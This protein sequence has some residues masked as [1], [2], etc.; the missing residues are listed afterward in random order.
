MN[1]EQLRNK[2]GAQMQ[3]N[4]STHLAK[5]KLQGHGIGRI[6]L[7]PKGLSIT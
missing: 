7:V 4:F 1:P 3:R 5:Y 2:I 6:Y